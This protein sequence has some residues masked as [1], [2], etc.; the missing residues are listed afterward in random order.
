MRQR[1]TLASRVLAESLVPGIL[2][3]DVQFVLQFDLCEHFFKNGLDCILIGDFLPEDLVEM[4]EQAEQP[5]D[6]DDV[7]ATGVLVHDVFVLDHMLQ[8]GLLDGQIA[9]QD[10]VEPVAV[11]ALCDDFVADIDRQELHVSHGDVEVLQRET[12]TV[13]RLEHLAEN[14]EAVH[15]PAKDGELLRRSVHDFLYGQNLEHR[16]DQPYVFGALH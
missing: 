1:R 10:H 11:V 2:T 6:G 12:T 9:F 14:F 13:V 7:L 5:I 4:L 15:V 3:L 16:F 8:E